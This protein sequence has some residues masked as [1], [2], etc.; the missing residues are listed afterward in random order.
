MRPAEPDKPA[1]QPVRPPYLVSEYGRYLGGAQWAVLGQNPPRV[2]AECKD[3]ATAR[4][5]ALAGNCF[6]ELLTAA[7][8]LTVAMMGDNQTLINEC[9]RKLRDA[10]AS[11]ERR[12][13]ATQ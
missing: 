2:A 8:C 7:Q 9:Y 11:A 10:I 3:E 6:E 1:V 13:H 4:F 12:A 5:L